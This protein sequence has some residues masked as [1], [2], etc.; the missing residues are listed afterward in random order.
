MA[1]RREPED[2]DEEPAPTVR[3]TVR[4]SDRLAEFIDAAKTLGTLGSTRAEVV[5]KF[6]ENEISRLIREGMIKIKPPEV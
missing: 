6:I 2:E 5:R 4:V 3:F 1:T